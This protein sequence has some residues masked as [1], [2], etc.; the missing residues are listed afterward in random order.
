M[1]NI[2]TL[3]CSCSLR[4][5][6]LL[7]AYST[8]LQAYLDQL[9]RSL[10]LEYRS[11][12]ISFQNQAPLYVATKMSKI[13]RPSLTAPS[14]QAWVNSAVRHI[15]YE[16]ITTPYW[17]HGLMWW[18]ISMVPEQFINAYVLRLHLGIRKRWYAKQKRSQ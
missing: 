10:S 17:V 18:A 14:P 2:S 16:A 6:R 13:R 7:T 4:C 3:E 8:C 5:C 12:G 1:P 11:Y 9:A 15:G